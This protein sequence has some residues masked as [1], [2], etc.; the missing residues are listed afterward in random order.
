MAILGITNRTENWKTAQHFAPLFGA[1]SV[2]LARRLLAHDDQ[3]TALR[4]G[5]VRLELFW[6]GMRDYMK[7]WPAQV[8]E[9]ENQIASIYESRFREVRQHVKES[10]EAGM[11]KKLTG[12][13]Y[14]ASNDGQKRRLRNNLRHTEIDIV[15]ESP[16]HLF[17]GEAKHESDFDGNSNFIL[18]HQLIRQYVMARIL[19][20]LSGGKREVVPFV[21]GDDSSVLNN[22]H[23]VQFMIKHCG[24]RKENVLTWSDIEALW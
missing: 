19:V 23:Q 9:Q 2:R 22:S 17:I 15:L 12:D 14:R 11:F 6:C 7:R 24:M 18:T 21:V 5:D 13:N 1:N 20:E 8:R 3:R 4:S 16:K 10:V